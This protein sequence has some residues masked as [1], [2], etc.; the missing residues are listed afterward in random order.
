[1]QNNSLSLFLTILFVVLGLVGPLIN[2]V[3]AQDVPGCA[4]RCMETA[5]SAVGCDSSSV[6]LPV[7]SLFIITPIVN[8]ICTVK[9]QVV[10]VDLLST[11]VLSDNAWIAHVML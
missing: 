6:L 11:S 5:S 7:L 3:Q 1:M 4:Q 9:I 8:E 2:S 10:F